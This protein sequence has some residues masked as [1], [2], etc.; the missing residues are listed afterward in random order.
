M[1]RAIPKG[2]RTI[3]S[4][5]RRTPS[6]TRGASATRVVAIIRM[7]SATIAMCQCEYCF[8]RIVRIGATSAMPA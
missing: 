4:T 2:T 6:L 7:M 8:S 5:T 3:M 1:L